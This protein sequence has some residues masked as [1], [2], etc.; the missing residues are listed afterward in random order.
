M[1]GATPERL[2]W[3]REQLAGR[4]AEELL[5]GE[6]FRPRGAWGDRPLRL[7]RFAFR[8]LGVGGMHPLE[9]RIG[10]LNL[11]AA[12]PTRLLLF[13]LRGSR[14]SIGVDDEIAGWPLAGLRIRHDRRSAQARH[15]SAAGTYSAHTS[16]IVVLR[17]EPPDEPPLEIDLAAGKD[18]AALVAALK[19][20]ASEAASGRRPRRA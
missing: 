6:I 19:T 1:A 15:W 11:A 3:L 7:R 20:S 17:I 18:A 13:R 12:T 8:H 2:E 10:L 14:S 16:G 4:V 5:A 9:R